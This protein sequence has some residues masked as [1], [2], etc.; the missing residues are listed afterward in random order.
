MIR[1]GLV[2][3][4]IEN[5]E[6]QV[7]KSKGQD[8]CTSAAC[9]K[10][11]TSDGSSEESKTCDLPWTLVNLHCWKQNLLPIAT[12][13]TRSHPSSL[14]L[15]WLFDGHWD[16]PSLPD[17]PWPCL[18]Q[19]RP[20]SS[21]EITYIISFQVIIIKRNG[22]PFICIKDCFKDEATIQLSFLTK[23]LFF[24]TISS[25]IKILNCAYDNNGRIPLLDLVL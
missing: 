6:E 9:L 10:S 25:H 8:F 23:P 19:L 1:L 21:S 22:R 13:L 11:H 15:T 16:P 5:I 24:W 18:L 7:S 3:N 20:L 4:T 14:T 12:K 17:Y 2:F